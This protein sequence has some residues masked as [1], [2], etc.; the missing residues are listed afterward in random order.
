MC[1]Y[2]KR[3]TTDRRRRTHTHKHTISEESQ[4]H[5]PIPS[6]TKLYQLFGQMQRARTSETQPNNRATTKPVY[7][8]GSTL[9]DHLF[10]SCLTYY[11]LDPTRHRPGSPNFRVTQWCV[12]A[13]PT[14]SRSCLDQIIHTKRPPLPPPLF[15]SLSCKCQKTDFRPVQ[16]FS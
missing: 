14:R 11:V 9:S 6:Q 5:S 1:L 2:L 15:T 16:R 8:G 3:G 4:Q 13:P 12:W 10:M 7:V